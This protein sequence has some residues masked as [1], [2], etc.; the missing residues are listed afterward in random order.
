MWRE[1]THNEGVS[2]QYRIQKCS[3]RDAIALQACP[4]TTLVVLIAL[5]CLFSYPR[6]GQ[7]TQCLIDGRDSGRTDDTCWE[8]GG[9]EQVRGRGTGPHEQ[10]AIWGCVCTKIYI[11]C[12]FAIE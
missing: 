2:K 6:T 7:M 1:S 3:Y 12:G 8:V 5:P 9:G 10:L 4:L 11:L